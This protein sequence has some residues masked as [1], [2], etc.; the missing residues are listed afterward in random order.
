MK[1][2]FN[3]IIVTILSLGVFL[4]LVVA[5]ATRTSTGRE[6]V[7]CKTLD[8]TRKASIDDPTARSNLA[9][10][11]QAW[12]GQP[13]KPYSDWH[14]LKVDKV[15]IPLPSGKWRR[16]ES[17]S[18]ATRFA[19]ESEQV[20]VDLHVYPY[21]YDLAAAQVKASTW[22]RW[23]LGEQLE[24][25]KQ[26]IIA[27]FRRD[28]AADC[29]P[30]KDFRSLLLQE[31]LVDLKSTATNS[32]RAFAARWGRAPSRFLIAY[33]KGGITTIRYTQKQGLDAWVVTY[34]TRSAI[35]ANQ[36]IDQ[37]SLI[38]KT[39]LATSSPPELRKNSTPRTRISTTELTDTSLPMPGELCQELIY[40][41]AQSPF[42]DTPSWVLSFKPGTLELSSEA[43][44]ALRKIIASIDKQSANIVL[45]TVI[46]TD[47]KS[48]VISSIHASALEGAV[49][50]WLLRN[51]SSTG[52]TILSDPTDNSDGVI[53]PAVIARLVPTTT[54]MSDKTQQRLKTEFSNATSAPVQNRL[55]YILSRRRGAETPVIGVA[56]PN[57][58][59][60]IA[61]DLTDNALR[62]AER[63]SDRKVLIKDLQHLP[64]LV[65]LDLA[66]VIS[67]D[68][69]ASLRDCLEVDF[70]LIPTVEGKL[71]EPARGTATALYELKVQIIE[72]STLDLIGTWTTI[73]SA[74]VELPS[75]QLL[76]SI[77]IPFNVD[78]DTLNEEALPQL[79]TVLRTLKSFPDASLRLRPTAFTDEVIGPD[80]KS[81][82]LSLAENRAQ[83]L[84][85]QLDNMRANT[86]LRFDNPS[87]PYCGTQA[88]ARGVLLE[89]WSEPE[90]KFWELSWLD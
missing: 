34:E 18:S 40:K 60:P 21:H 35:I 90:A 46:G 31:L 3:Q 71:E 33:E 5:F 39:N 44:T 77:P 45:S 55:S 26:P 43:V 82:C 7:F 73:H 25:I 17:D 66:T 11:G 78:S 16:I 14:Y 61:V 68:T 22:Q 75:R 36:L 65:N 6:L 30:N 88:W 15:L 62:L 24:R 4:A 19:A 49:R 69:A 50:Y 64:S 47:I 13:P 74:E 42:L 20:R 2:F 87:Q 51:S 37:A 70:L 41:W 72:L 80:Q 1:R 79:Q 52:L 56:A 59:G 63:F 32:G 29:D 57:I 28:L 84:K 89:I 8:T 27:A 10:I 38:V 53:G 76:G 54:E 12:Q 83:A 48:G 85:K 23:I 58:Q 81:A 9:V 67:M 86:P